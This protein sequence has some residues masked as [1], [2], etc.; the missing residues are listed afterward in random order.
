MT[1]TQIQLNEKPSLGGGSHIE[2]AL[3][4]IP[5]VQDVKVEPDALRVTVQ[6]ED[7]DETK[8]V[9]AIRATALPA[10][11]IPQN[12]EVVAPSVPK[13]ETNS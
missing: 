13:M 3:R 10:D 6:H 2:K 12:A 1:T 4:A 7:V 8:L 11:L 9:E 5:G